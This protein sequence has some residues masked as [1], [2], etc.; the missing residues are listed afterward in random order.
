[1]NFLGKTCLLAMC[2]FTMFGGAGV[3]ASAVSSVKAIKQA[4]VYRQVEQKMLMTFGEIVEVNEKQIVI[5]G[6]GV[7]QLIAVN[8]DD[9]T[10]L[11]NGKNGKAKSLRSFKVGKK[12]AA[13]YSP[14]MTRSIPPQAKGFALV[15]GENTERYGKFFTVDKVALSE[16]GKYVSV[17]NNAHNI[18]ATVDREACKNY[19]DIKEGDN[20]LMWYSMMTMSLPAKTNAE[21]AVI[22]PQLD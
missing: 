21:K 15:L 20:L 2:V 14:L 19:A 8:V 13:Y 11:L 17:M 3:E 6:E 22:L 1:M 18:I 16:D 7:R 4:P 5:K 9:S 12:V 10:Y